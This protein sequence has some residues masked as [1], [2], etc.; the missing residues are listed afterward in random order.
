MCLRLEAAGIAVPLGA[1][2]GH[3][4]SCGLVVPAE[5]QPLC[6][7]RGLQDRL[8]APASSAV[9]PDEGL[10]VYSS[11]QG[12]FGRSS[13]TFLSPALQPARSAWK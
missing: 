3:G 5:G 1:E 9:R 7:L 8:G 11:N 13:K 6:R 12:S 2:A 4:K 10:T